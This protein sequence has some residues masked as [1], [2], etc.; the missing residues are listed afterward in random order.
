MVDTDTNPYTKI[1]NNIA[2]MGTRP[3]EANN[4]GVVDSS[5]DNDMGVPIYTEVYSNRDQ[6]ESDAT[7]LHENTAYISVENRE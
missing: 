1:E 3:A 5:L 7:E 2:D 6:K 4:S